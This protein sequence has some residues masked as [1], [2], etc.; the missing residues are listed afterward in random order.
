MTVALITIALDPRGV[1][2]G[3]QTTRPVWSHIGDGVHAAGLA[4]GTA[5]LGLV[6]VKL[7]TI[8][9]ERATELALVFLLFSD[10]T[11]IDL[12]GHAATWVGRV[13]SC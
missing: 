5:G 11:R 7:E 4:V 8:V 13:A 2:R 3:L 12:A 10:S 9:A 1:R 6:D